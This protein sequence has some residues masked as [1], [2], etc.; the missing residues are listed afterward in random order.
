M[1]IQQK[2]KD[3]QDLIDKEREDDPEGQSP[4]ADELQKKAAAAILGGP[5]EIETYMR[6]FTDDPAELA[7]L[8]PDVTATSPAHI[9]R[10]LASAYLMGNG[11]CGAASGKGPSQGLLFQV[12]GVHDE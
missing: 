12:S 1:S 9:G 3:V 4:T 5:A 2:I 7:R 6:I 8:M 10:N 11:N